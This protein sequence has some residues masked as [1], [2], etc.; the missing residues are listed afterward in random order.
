MAS[1]E[2]ESKDLLLCEWCGEYVSH[3][4]MYLYTPGDVVSNPNWVCADCA[5]GDE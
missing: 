1:A 4:E 2:A 5:E 3:R